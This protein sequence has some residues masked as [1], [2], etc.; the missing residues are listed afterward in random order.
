MEE[1]QTVGEKHSDNGTL[2]TLYF[3]YIHTDSDEIE[4]GY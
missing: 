2:H 4:G 1:V 3:S